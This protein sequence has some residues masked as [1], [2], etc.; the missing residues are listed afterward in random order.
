VVEGLG[1]GFLPELAVQAEIASGVLAALPWEKRFE[2]QL[3]LVWPRHKWLSPVEE[4]WVAVCTGSAES[5]FPAGG[6]AGER[7]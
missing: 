7:G 4:R 3:Q 5:V 1:V 2:V 6:L